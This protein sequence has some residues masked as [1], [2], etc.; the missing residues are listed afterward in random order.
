MI[1]VVPAQIIL[2]ILLK[3]LGSRCVKKVD[4]KLRDTRELMI[5]RA[6]KL[7]TLNLFWAL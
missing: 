2:I 7:L 1:N 6:Y 3:H 4:L 5:I